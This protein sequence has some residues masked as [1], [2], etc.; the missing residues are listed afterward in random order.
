VL[1]PARDEAQTIGTSSHFFITEITL[2]YLSHWYYLLIFT[3]IKLSWQYTQRNIW[4]L[5]KN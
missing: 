2:F 3:R 1:A 4:Q 5:K